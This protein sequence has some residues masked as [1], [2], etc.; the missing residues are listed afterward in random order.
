MKITEEFIAPKLQQFELKNLARSLYSRSQ[1]I[2][3]EYLEL[4]AANMETNISYEEYVILVNNRKI[5]K[6]MLSA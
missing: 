2:V 5:W 6:E 4:K 1:K 3:N